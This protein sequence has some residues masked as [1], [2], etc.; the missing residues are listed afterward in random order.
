MQRNVEPQ[1][2]VTLLSAFALALAHSAATRGIGNV[3]RNGTVPQL[4]GFVMESLGPGFDLTRSCRHHHDDGRYNTQGPR[5]HDPCYR[6]HWPLTGEALAETITVT[7]AIK[8][9][10]S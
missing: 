7:S 5:A 1:E 3:I 4:S 8:L 6:T 9:I 10:D 2:F